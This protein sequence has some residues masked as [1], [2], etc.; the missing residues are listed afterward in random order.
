MLENVP[1]LWTKV[2]ELSCHGLC[3]S[4]SKDSIYLP[5]T[6]QLP[7]NLLSNSFVKAEVIPCGIYMRS[8]CF[9][10]TVIHS[11]LGGAEVFLIP[12]DLVQ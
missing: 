2:M 12:K 11:A 9:L 3:F 6:S 8:L 10:A 7:P 1:W 5:S 4:E